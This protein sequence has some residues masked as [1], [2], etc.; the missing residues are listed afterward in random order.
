[1]KD[2]IKILENTELFKCF[3]SEELENIFDERYYTVKDYE[4]NS[5]IYLQNEKCESLDVILNGIITIQKIDQDGKILT[6]SD[7]MSGDVLG[8]NLLFSASSNYPMTITA[9]TDCT[10]L[11]MKSSLVLALCQKNECFL[12]SF[13][14]SLSSKTLI[15]SNKIKSLTMKT[16]RQL[17]IDFLLIESFSQGSTNVKLNMTKKD[18][19]EKLGVQRSSLSRE[20]N[21]MR[22]DGLVEYNSNYIYIKDIESM[23]HFI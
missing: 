9:K 19:A 21:K 1:M 12:K 18:L 4:K 6:I 17:I 13:L 11:H 10:L 7:F 15:L 23:K 20:L 8:E 3:N 14:M 16:I 5:I 22:N 2:F